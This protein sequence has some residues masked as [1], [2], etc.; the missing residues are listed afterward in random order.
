MTTYT[1]ATATANADSVAKI[2]VRRMDFGFDQ[3]TEQD[4]FRNNPILS[5]F[6]A[7][8]SGT[9]PP[10]EQMFIQSVR[11][12]KDQ[13][14]GDELQEAVRLFTQQEAHHTH[15]H[16]LANQRLEELGWDALAIEKRVERAI[17]FLNRKRSPESRLAMT[18]CLEHLTAIVA[19][20]VLTHPEHFE[21]MDL[22]VRNML[23]WHAIEEIEH[24]SVAFDVY[25]QVCGDRKALRRMMNRMAFMFPF[26]TTLRTIYLLARARRL[27]R[28]KHV[29]D[30]RGMLTGPTGMLTCLKQP[31]KDFYQDDFHPDDHDN[32]G[33]VE[34]W[35]AE[36]DQYRAG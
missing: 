25:M 15:Q 20:F 35:K 29:R 11:H 31:L 2:E 36:V 5:A 21:G 26:L 24:K 10:G 28:W 34:Q 9:F 22:S 6:M 30:A 3:V 32:R 18:V 27:P 13:I 1:A 12:F 33:L 19:E 7:V 4:W 14:Q 8:L 17:Y 16:K 23:I